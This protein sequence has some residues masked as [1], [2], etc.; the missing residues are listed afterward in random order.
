M[1]W[2]EPC[3]KYFVTTLATEPLIKNVVNH[4]FDKY[5]KAPGINLYIVLGNK[6]PICQTF[7]SPSCISAYLLSLQ[8]MPAQATGK[9]RKAHKPKPQQQPAAK[10]PR[11]EKDSSFSQNSIFQHL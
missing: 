3:C 4:N 1:T 11:L 8:A 2:T 10:K 6:K 9:V 7:H 5:M